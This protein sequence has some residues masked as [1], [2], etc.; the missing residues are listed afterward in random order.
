M[1]G[2]NAWLSCWNAWLNAQGFRE[3]SRKPVISL[4]VFLTCAPKYAR[5]TLWRRHSRKHKYRRSC[6]VRLVGPGAS[7]ARLNA[8]DSAMKV[9][10]RYYEMRGFSVGLHGRDY[11]SSRVAFTGS[12]ATMKKLY[13]LR[14][15]HC[16]YLKRA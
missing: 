11:A 12:K 15:R 4:S 10:S 3:T 5:S 7:Q 8:R 9:L 6:T 1:R 13:V 14:G 16:T 2:R